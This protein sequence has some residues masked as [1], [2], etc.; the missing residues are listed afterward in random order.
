VSVT[1]ILDKIIQNGTG[2][3]TNNS[4]TT[5]ISGFIDDIKFK[6][7]GENIEVSGL[8]HGSRLMLYTIN[9]QR[10]VNKICLGDAEVLNVKRGIYIAKI[11]SSRQSYELKLIV[12]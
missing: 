1:N 2:V 7:S 9:G 4:I 6:T 5:V 8:A 10:I 12:Q 11:I 3:F